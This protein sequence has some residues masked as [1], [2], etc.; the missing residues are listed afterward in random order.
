MAGSP[1]CFPYTIATGV[2]LHEMRDTA[3]GIWF[4]H[5]EQVSWGFTTP[6][7]RLISKTIRLQ[8]SAATIGAPAILPGGLLSF[9]HSKFHCPSILDYKCCNRH[10]ISFKFIHLCH[11][12]LFRC[13]RRL[14]KLSL[15]YHDV[16]NGIFSNHEGTLFLLAFF[17]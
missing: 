14:Q 7:S 9:S 2:K 6:W 5:I 3:K 15:A 12:A 17:T 10:L 16:L 11:L 8:G 1:R 13:Q 4:A